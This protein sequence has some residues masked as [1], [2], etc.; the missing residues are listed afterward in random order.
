MD[1]VDPKIVREDPDEDIPY[2]SSDG[3]GDT[4]TDAP[5]GLTSDPSAGELALEDEVDRNDFDNDDDLQ[6]A[7]SSPEFQHLRK[8]PHTA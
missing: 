5:D 3:V 7:G 6:D 2:I 4:I 1:N 8:R